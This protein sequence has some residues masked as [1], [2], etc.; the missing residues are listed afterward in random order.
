[1][2]AK[3]FTVR[4]VPAQLTTHC[5]RYGPACPICAIVDQ[6]ILSHQGETITGLMDMVK[7]RIEKNRNYPAP[8]PVKKGEI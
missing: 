5:Q 2:A 4:T 1:M 8:K 7:L 3:E 6:F